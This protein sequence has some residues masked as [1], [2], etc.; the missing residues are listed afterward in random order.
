MCKMLCLVAVLLLALGTVPGLATNQDPV[1]DQA[2][3]AVSDEFVPV[4][5]AGP[6]ELPWSIGFLPDGSILITEKPGRLSLVRSDEAP[7]QI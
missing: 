7:A 4:P 1:E 5:I 2:V 6:F 3:E